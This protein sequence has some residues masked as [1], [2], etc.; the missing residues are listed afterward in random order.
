MKSKPQALFSLA[1]V[2]ALLLSGC[3]GTRTGDEKPA[4]AALDKGTVAVVNGEA[5]PYSEFAEQMASVEMLYS[6]LAGTR[7]EE[8]IKTMLEAEAENVLETL[9]LQ[10]VL[11]QKVEEYGITLTEAEEQEARDAWTEVREKIAASVA[12]N[13]PDYSGEELEALVQ[14]AVESS[15]FREETVVQ[16]ARQSALLK[17]L[18]AAALSDAS[19]AVSDSAVEERYQERL[20]EETIQFDTDVT[21]FEAAMLG[22]TA[23]VYIPRPYRVL[24]ELD[25]RFD[26]DMLSVLAQLKEYDTEDDDTYE[27][28]L[29]SERALLEEKAQAVRA[30][31]AGGESAEALAAEYGGRVNYICEDTTRFSQDYY[32]AAF[33]IGEIG[34]AADTL[35]EL[36]NGGTLLC[37]TGTLSPGPVP[38]EE[39]A[40]R[41]REEI[42]AEKRTAAWSAQQSSWRDEAEVVINEELLSYR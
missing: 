39:A 34:G 14:I 12:R 11:M 8:E 28:L 29:A 17:K 32:D 27:T 31:L 5:V 38:L 19:L 21:A 42:A 40:G 10:R 18:Q 37:W 13:Y 36:D 22:K 24:Q 3:A 4:P 15:N 26:D 16:S 7:G 30:R 23:A 25:L 1:L 33:S 6:S 2:L 20:E 41:I 9:I 35:I